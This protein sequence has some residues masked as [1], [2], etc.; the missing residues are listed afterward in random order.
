MS[1]RG[2]TEMKLSP[3]KSLAISPLDGRY[4]DKISELSKFVSEYALIKYRTEVEI[5]YLIALSEIGIIKKLNKKNKDF[6][7]S[8]YLKFD[9][10]DAERIKILEDETRHDIKAV[11]KYLREEFAKTPLKD[12]SEMIHFGLTSED[13]NNIAYRLMLKS[14]IEAIVLPTLYEVLEKLNEKAKKYKKIVILGRTHGQPA[15]PTTFGKEFAVFAVRLEKEIKLL[16][17]QKLTGKLNGAVGNY[18]ALDFAYPKFSWIKFSK[19]F[20]SS[21]NL[22]PNLITTQINPFEDVIS[23]FQTLERINGILLDFDQDVWRYISDGW[24]KLAFKG[25]EVGSSTMPQKVNPIDFENSEGNLTLAN[26]L[27]QTIN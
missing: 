23:L 18:N 5:R 27:S 17:K 15:V 12:I 7:I 21:F 22:E 6:L 24:L 1:Q 2:K 25:N 14:A 4:A 11:E 8:I 13:I 26:G 9:I 16:Q 3:S 20:V 19:N 10:N